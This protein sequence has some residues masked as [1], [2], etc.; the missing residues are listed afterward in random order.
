MIAALVNV[1]TS[2]AT[3]TFLSVSVECVCMN[4]DFF[5]LNEG[6]NVQWIMSLCV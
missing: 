5:F 1:T 2:L 4:Y 3:F 6:K